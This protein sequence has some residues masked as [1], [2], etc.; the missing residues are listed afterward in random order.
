MPDDFQPRV[1]I[2]KMFNAGMLI[3]EE[4]MQQFSENFAIETHLIM[5]IAHLEDLKQQ[6][7][8]L[9]EQGGAQNKGLN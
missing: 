4:Q 5:Y 7:S 9:R 8:I 1:K 3:T 6:S 2:K